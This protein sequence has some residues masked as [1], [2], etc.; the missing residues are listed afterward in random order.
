MGKTFLTQAELCNS[1]TFFRPNR[2]VLVTTRDRDGTIHIAPFAWCV[3]AS[4]D[5]PIVTL[6]L[7]ARPRKQH[8]LVNIERDREFVVNLPGHDLSADLV[9]ASYRYPAGVYK[10][11][12]LGFE[13]S[14]SQRVDVPFIKA[15]RAHVECRL[16]TS[17]M[18]GDHTLLVADVVAASYV[19][20]QYH[21]GFIPDV[22]KYPPCLHL[23]HRQTPG[24]QMHSFIV[25]DGVESLDLPYN[26]PGQMSDIQAGCSSPT[27]TE[28]GKRS[29]VGQETWGAKATTFA[30]GFVCPE[31]PCSDG[32]GDLFVVDWAV[33]VVRRVTPEGRVTDFIDTGGM[34]AGACFGPNGQLAVC[35]TGRKE[36]LSITQDG[37]IR[38]AASRYQEKPFLGPTDCTFDPQGNLYFSDADGF[39]PLAPSGNVYMLRP[40]GEV[41]LFAGGFAFPNGLAI[42]NDGTYLYMAETFAN[43]IHRFRLDEQGHAKDQE[44]FTQLQGGLGPDGLAL[45]EAGNLYAA[46]FG[47]G[48][49]AVLDPEGKRL[50]ELATGGF[51]PT[52]VTFW[53]SSLYVTEL[54]RGCLMRLD[55]T[56]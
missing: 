44:V 32:D 27:D 56:P 20:E 48:V 21:E 15:A 39:H 4:Y 35:D 8:S 24:G 1:I 49:V 54:E 12:I 33:G 41:E 43:R 29:E 3:P 46:H 50:A 40:G 25:G 26:L 45:D 7:L 16:K 53:N 14:P 37:V 10:V 36:V 42:S 51:L 47:K 6:A 5:P 30:A 2:P 52:N 55:V 34:P 38:A 18:T 17:L 13:F 19:P 28:M 11:G 31:G 22:E 23:G 9:R